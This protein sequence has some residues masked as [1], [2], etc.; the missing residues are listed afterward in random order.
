MRAKETDVRGL[1]S[2]NSSMTSLTSSSILT[3]GCGISGRG[4]RYHGVVRF[5]AAIDLRSPPGILKS[6]LGVSA[7]IL[8]K[9]NATACPPIH[10]PDISE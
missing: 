1:V 6:S 7:E 4:K 5:T 10:V 2:T 9:S 8:P 3:I